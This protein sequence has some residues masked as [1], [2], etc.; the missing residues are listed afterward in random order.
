ME[1]THVL[2]G[3]SISLASFKT[4]TSRDLVTLLVKAVCEVL[5]KYPH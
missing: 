3:A 4:K 2:L 5:F 1:P